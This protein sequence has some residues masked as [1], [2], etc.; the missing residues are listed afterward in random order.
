MKKTV[1]M[2]AM[3]FFTFSLWAQ[4]GGRDPESEDWV[5]PSITDQSKGREHPYYISAA[6]YTTYS[7]DVRARLDKQLF[8]SILDILG[9]SKDGKVLI[10]SHW[11]FDT[12]FYIVN[13][14]DD[15]VIDLSEEFET[16][17]RDSFKFADE[18]VI[19][20]FILEVAKKYNIEPSAG[21]VGTFPYTAAAGKTYDVSYKEKTVLYHRSVRYGDTYH[22]SIDAYLNQ[23]FAPNKTKLIGAI[24]QE[25]ASWNDLERGKL[26]FWYARSPFENRVAVIPALPIWVSGIYDV[27]VYRLNLYGSHLEAGF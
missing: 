19:K 1:I 22:T 20:K 23:K 14:V 9:W 13:L 12:S 21:T 4:D 15:R 10:F 6:P 26:K 5:D 24:E 17:H 8:S 25:R 16:I 2:I 3:A 11:H 27:Y 7:F 18:A